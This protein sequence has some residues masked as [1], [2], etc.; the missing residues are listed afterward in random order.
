MTLENPYQ[1]PN[2]EVSGAALS[3]WEDGTLELHSF[4][5]T[6]DH[7]AFNM[8]YLLKTGAGRAAVHVRRFLPALVLFPLSG[9]LLDMWLNSYL[10]LMIAVMASVTWWFGWPGFIRTSI[11]RQVQTL[12][13][14]GKNLLA[15]GD[16]WIAVS[17]REIRRRTPWCHLRV[18]WPA[19]ERIDVTPHH[20]FL[21]ISANSAFII[22]T[23]DFP[24]ESTRQ[25]FLATIARFH[26]QAESAAPL[27]AESH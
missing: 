4:L 14:G 23:R 11:R 5:S 10:P 15:F 20:V 1:S 18:L 12:L 3:R 19:V 21:Y 6:E 7:V 24:D 2:P 16:Q 13:S 9:L 22:P 25:E 27:A 26:Q 8:H 17:P